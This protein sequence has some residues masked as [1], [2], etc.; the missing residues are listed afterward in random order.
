M[1]ADKG[2]WPARL[3]KPDRLQG[4]LQ[5]AELDALWGR[6][7]AAADGWFVASAGSML[8]A[9]PAPADELRQAVDRID[10]TLRREHRLAVCGIVY[11][12]DPAAP[13]YIEIFD[14]VGLG[15]MCSHDGAPPLPRWVLSRS[16]P[17]AVPA[18]PPSPRGWWQRWRLG[19]VQV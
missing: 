5:W 6:V 12:D 15:T 8:P 4:V 3:G 16:A 1:T 11:V 14:P 2:N 7:R 10:A 9:A 13:G 17:V 19:K 18:V